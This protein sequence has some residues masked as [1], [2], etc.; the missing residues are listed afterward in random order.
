MQ[1]CK[2]NSGP[3]VRGGAIPGKKNK[4]GRNSAEYLAGVL[5]SD[6]QCLV[7]RFETSLVEL[8]PVFEEYEWI[9]E[10]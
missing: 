8:L 10:R 6:L 1:Q 3:A 9:Y 7:A 2:S 4:K 5:C